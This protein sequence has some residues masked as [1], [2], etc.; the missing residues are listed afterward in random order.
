MDAPTQRPGEPLTT[1][2]ASGAGPGPELFGQAAMNPIDEI[3]AMYA[4][5]P[6]DDMLR[7]LSYL[8]GGS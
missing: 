2:I 5:D 4:A 1:G 8:D 7:L 3:R 6:N